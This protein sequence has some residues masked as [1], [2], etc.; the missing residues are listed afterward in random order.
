MREKFWLF[1]IV[2]WL[3]G[4]WQT[5]LCAETVPADVRTAAEQGVSR[6][7]D[8]IPDDDLN[9]FGFTKEAEL[10]QTTL[11]HP[12]PVYTIEPLRILDYQGE[13]DIAGLITSMDSWLFPVVCGGS[14]RVLLTVA[15]WEEEWRAVDLG[16]SHLA[17]EIEQII[18]SWEGLI[19]RLPTDEN[20]PEGSEESQKQ[21]LNNLKLI[22]IYQANCDFLLV[23]EDGASYLIPL[24]G[25]ARALGLVGLGESYA[26]GV[27][28]T[29]EA[30]TRLTPLVRESLES[31]VEGH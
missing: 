31:Q 17:T 26:H 22:R 1:L 29:A 12:L 16:A 6:F 9:R 30:L 24:Q 27:M 23:S 13:E 10:S 11:G 28:N 14:Y 15:W 18:Q 8:A 4:S 20:E 21:A 7:L 19:G 2:C 25:T 5:L 3:L